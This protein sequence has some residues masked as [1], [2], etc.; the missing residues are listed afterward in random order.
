MYSS[1]VIDLTGPAPALE[2]TVCAPVSFVKDLTY[3]SNAITL[4]E[5]GFLAGILVPVLFYIGYVY[6]APWVYAR[7]PESL[8]ERIRGS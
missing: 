2:P 3:S 6:A 7:L 8:I 5:L 4:G 1:N